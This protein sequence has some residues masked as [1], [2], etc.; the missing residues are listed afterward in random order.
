MIEYMFDHL[1]LETMGKHL[2]MIIYT[3][4]EVL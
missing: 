2:I 4:T 3:L 1:R